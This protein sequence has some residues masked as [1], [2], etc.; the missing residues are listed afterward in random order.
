MCASCPRGHGQPQLEHVHQPA[1]PPL[2]DRQVSPGRGA[3][4]STF[5]VFR[6]KSYHTIEARLDRISDDLGVHDEYLAGVVTG[7]G[8]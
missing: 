1:T 3:A 6:P 2:R 5:K 7:F 4:A 8:V